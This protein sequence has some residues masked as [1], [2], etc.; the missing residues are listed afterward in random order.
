MDDFDAS[1]KPAR[2]PTASKIVVVDI[3]CRTTTGFN[4]PGWFQ[5]A[6][7]PGPAKPSSLRNPNR[8]IFRQQGDRAATNRRPTN[9][10]RLTAHHGRATP[11]MT[12]GICTC[13]QGNN[14]TL[15]WKNKDDARRFHQNHRF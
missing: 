14:R 12:N 3:I 1:L 7:L 11:D 15:D 5:K 8:P 10:N 6:A 9:Q 4:Y 2:P 13:S